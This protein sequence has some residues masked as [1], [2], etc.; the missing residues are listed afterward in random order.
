MIARPR[1]EHDSRRRHWH[2]TPPQAT[3]TPTRLTPHR[4][5]PPAS[6]GPR[7]RRPTSRAAAALLTLVLACLASGWGVARLTASSPPMPALPPSPQA[8]LHAYLTAAVDKPREVCSQLFAPALARVYA[9]YAPGS[10]T[11]FFARATSSSKQAVRRIL[12][13]GSTAVIELRQKTGAIDW[14]VVLARRPSGWQ[15]IDLLGGRL[16]R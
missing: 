9:D 14:A 12:K 11:R 7:R 13:D 10:C 16:L 4:Q 15:A 6:T 5:L 1:G 3:T 2:P 8:W